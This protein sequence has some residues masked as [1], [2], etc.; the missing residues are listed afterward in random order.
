MEDILTIIAGVV[1]MYLTF[2]IAIWFMGAR[3]RYGESRMY[4]NEYRKMG[5]FQKELFKHRYYRDR[6]SNRDRSSNRDP[7]GWEDAEDWAM[8]LAMRDTRSDAEV[9]AEWKA[10]EAMPSL[11]E[12]A[13]ASAGE[14]RRDDFERRATAAGRLNEQSLAAADA[15]IKAWVVQEIDLDE[16]DRRLGYSHRAPSG[17]LFRIEFEVRAAAK[18]RLNEQSL[19]A[20]DAAIKAWVEEEIDDDELDRRIGIR[21]NL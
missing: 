7:D 4:G 13:L 1:M 14:R 9:V 17:D 11:L 15:A 5:E 19:A 10:R 12:R 6:G 2:R 3:A 20:A 21:P 8:D 16:L 18:G